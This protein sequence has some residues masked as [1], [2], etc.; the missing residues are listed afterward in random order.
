[1]CAWVCAFARD[2]VRAN[3]AGTNA[4]GPLQWVGKV[5]ALGCP[6]L[7]VSFSEVCTHGTQEL[8]CALAG[9]PLDTTYPSQKPAVLIS[10][11]QM[12]CARQPVTSTVGELDVIVEVSCRDIYILQKIDPGTLLLGPCCSLLLQ[13][14]S[15]P[16]PARLIRTALGLTSGRTC[17]PRVVH[18][19]VHH[20]P[21]ALRLS[22]RLLG[23]SDGIK[24]TQHLAARTL[25][26]LQVT[27]N[28]DSRAFNS[29]PALGLNSGRTS[30][31]RVVHKCVQ[32]L[33]PLGL[34]LSARLLENIFVSGRSLG[35]I[36]SSFYCC[37][38]AKASGIDSLQEVDGNLGR[39][40]RDVWAGRRTY[41]Q[42]RAP[43]PR[44]L[45]LG[46]IE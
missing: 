41:Q 45:H 29:L 1:M 33:L 8:Y 37:I 42:Q 23:F 2:H 11:A 34:R 43:H 38:A 40:F 35:S 21:L 6:Q 18:K 26:L 28:T 5:S 7:L 10:G 13:L 9:T 3:K 15:M 27:S 44:C 24:N 20:L 16:T 14:T 39:M 30:H 46:W 32:C 25:L 22:A 4:H 12:T 36:M 19:C 17:H 31:P